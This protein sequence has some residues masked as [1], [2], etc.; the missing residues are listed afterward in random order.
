MSIKAILS[1][2]PEQPEL[3]LCCFTHGTEHVR[4]SHRGHLYLAVMEQ[5]T[6]H[7]LETSFDLVRLKN[8]IG[9]LIN[10]AMHI[11]TAK[12]KICKDYVKNTYMILKI[13]GCEILLS[14]IGFN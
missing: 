7:L 10:E 12:I 13:I 5:Q 9:K 2:S 3:A 8:E 4:I 11:F 1:L 14:K 6:W